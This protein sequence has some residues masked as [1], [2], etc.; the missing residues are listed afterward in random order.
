LVLQLHKTD[1]KGRQVGNSDK[2]DKPKDDQVKAED[3]SVEKI[4]DVEVVE[5]T[6]AVDPVELDEPGIDDGEDSLEDEA[7]DPDFDQTAPE[8]ELAVAEVINEPAPEPVAVQKRRGGFVPLV[9]GGVVAAA[10]GFGGAVYFGEQLGIGANSDA[11]IA[12]I[13]AELT[14]QAVA[15]TA[16]KDSQTQTAT[17]AGDASAGLET[18]RAEI[19]SRIGE[20]AALSEAVAGFET[21]LSDIEKR[22]I[23]EGLS[24]AAIAAYER[25]VEDLKELVATQKA[26]AAELKDKA[27]IS[28][29]AALARSAV[30]RVIAALDSGAGYSGALVDLRSASGTEVPVVLADNAETGVLTLG[31]L[32]EAYPEAAR[33]ALAKARVD[34]VDDAQGSELGNFL[35]NQLG[36]RSVEAREGSDT[37]AI[38]SRSE[39]YLRD[40]NL[41]EALAELDG[42]AEGPKSLMSEWQTLAL[43][44]LSA[45]NAA[46]AL[47]QSLNTN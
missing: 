13:T 8:E 24:A 5:E 20:V 12:K 47:S 36:A 46:N 38:L 18:L 34:K 29:K 23:T 27:D 35:K 17:Q 41:A 2:T 6:D 25:E 21:R 32:S 10:V 9:L 26:D 45:V 14:T 40:G 44:R 33:A 42:L 31:A 39:A 3:A 19:D 16:L 22:P 11:E 37:D 7:R 15:L 1:S 43:T 28:A 4:E 30:T